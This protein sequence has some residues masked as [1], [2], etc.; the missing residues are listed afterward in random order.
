MEFGPSSSSTLVLHADLRQAAAA[1]LEEA[2]LDERRPDLDGSLDEAHDV[3]HD[4]LQVLLEEVRL[5][6][7]ERLVE[8]LREEPQRQGPLF[9][10]RA[11]RVGRLRVQRAD[12]REDLLRVLRQNLTLVVE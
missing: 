6:S 9:R 11:R 7:V 5:E 2:N 8:V 10:R 4:L 3:V 1:F 12:F